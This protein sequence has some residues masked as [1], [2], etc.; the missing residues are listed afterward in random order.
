MPIEERAK[1]VSD[2]L[3]RQEEDQET[4]VKVLTDQLRK[5]QAQSATQIDNSAVLHE[6]RQTDIKQSD[7]RLQFDLNADR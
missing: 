7:V 2:E 5:L 1:F 6:R 3:N 4:K